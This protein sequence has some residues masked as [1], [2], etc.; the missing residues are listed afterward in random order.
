MRILE[1][2]EQLY[3][4]GEGPGANRPHGSEAED[5]AHALAARWMAEAGLE[6]EVDPSGN[7]LGCS[8]PRD[9][10]WVGSHLDDNTGFF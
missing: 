9:D 8:G 5:E 4:I 2:L 7:L 3:A 1:R 6:V 10:V